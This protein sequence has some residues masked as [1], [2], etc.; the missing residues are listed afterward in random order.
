[1]YLLS[2]FP[3]EQ[4][5]G[6]YTCSTKDPCSTTMQ[7]QIP[8]CTAQVAGHTSMQSDPAKLRET[9]DTIPAPTYIKKAKKNYL[10]KWGVEDFSS[11]KNRFHI[12]PLH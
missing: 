11:Y 6:Y 10:M 3:Y 2:S 12:I 1:M 7:L 5:L 8:P 4:L 9:S